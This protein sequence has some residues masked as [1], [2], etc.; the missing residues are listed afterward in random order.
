M[1]RRFDSG[2]VSQ[3]NLNLTIVILIVMAGKKLGL[4]FATESLR[5]LALGGG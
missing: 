5:L 1:E 3:R 4:P 2:Q